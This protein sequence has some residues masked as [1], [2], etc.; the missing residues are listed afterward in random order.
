MVFAAK[1]DAAL[2]KISVSMVEIHGGTKS[3]D[4]QFEVR[5]DEIIEALEE[6]TE[7]AEADKET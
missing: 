1:T 5:V 7:N 2:F 4:L 6:D 3:R